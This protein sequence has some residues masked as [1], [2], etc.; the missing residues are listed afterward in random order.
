MEEA[1]KIGEYGA[2][3]LNCYSENENETLLCLQVI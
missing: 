3:K 1:I 2:R